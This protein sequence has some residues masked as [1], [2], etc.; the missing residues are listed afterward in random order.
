[1][2]ERRTLR[3]EEVQNGCQEEVPFLTREGATHLIQWPGAMFGLSRAID[4]LLNK[5]RPSIITRELRQL[6]SSVGT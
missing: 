4:F 2:L 5:G 3:R 1:M 6:V